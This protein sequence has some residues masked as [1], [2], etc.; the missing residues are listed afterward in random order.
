MLTSLFYVTGD[1]HRFL[2]RG[3]ARRSHQKVNA[4][5]DKIIDIGKE[6]KEPEKERK[7]EELQMGGYHYLVAHPSTNTKTR[8]L[9]VLNY[10]DPL[11]GRQVIK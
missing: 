5:G 11:M 2:H 4:R 1:F 3:R 6:N 8:I 9:P 7:S 10:L